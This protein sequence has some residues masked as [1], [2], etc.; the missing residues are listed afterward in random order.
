MEPVCTLCLPTELASLKAGLMISMMIAQWSVPIAREI[1]RERNR[2]VYVCAPASLCVC[3]GL[4]EARAKYN[5]LRSHI[6]FSASIFNHPWVCNDPSYARARHC[7]RMLTFIKKPSLYHTSAK[8]RSTTLQAPRYILR[9][10]L[11]VP[12]FVVNGTSGE[13]YWYSFSASSSGGRKIFQLIMPPS[14]TAVMSVVIVGNKL[15]NLFGLDPCGAGRPWSIGNSRNGWKLI[16]LTTGMYFTTFS[17]AHWDENS[18]A[19][20]SKGGQPLK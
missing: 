8:Q 13:G 5:L 1:E 15:T 17:P 3:V 16:Y 6:F 18:F 11:S 20:V 2:S 19:F 12:L 14:P 4:S 7:R 10:L 9:G